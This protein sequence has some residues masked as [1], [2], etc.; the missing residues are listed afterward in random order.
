M[1]NTEPMRC[2]S[3]WLPK[4]EDTYATRS[5]SPGA[6]GRAEGWASGG[7]ASRAATEAQNSAGRPADAVYHENQ[8]E[9]V[10]PAIGV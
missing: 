6:R 5:R 10:L 3:G 1:P 2:D 8:G 9:Q 4:S 7:S